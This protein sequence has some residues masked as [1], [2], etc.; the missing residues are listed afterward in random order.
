MLLGQKGIKIKGG[1]KKHEKLNDETLL[2][3]K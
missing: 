1:S 3:T 2:F